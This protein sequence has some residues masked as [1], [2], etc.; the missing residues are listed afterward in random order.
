MGR[1]S[2]EESAQRWWALSLAVALATD[3]GSGNAA[4]VVPGSDR[5]PIADST[6]TIVHFDGSTAETVPEPSSVFGVMEGNLSSGG[7]LAVPD[8]VPEPGNAALLGLGLRGF[9]VAKR[10][11]L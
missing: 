2:D 5:M 10:R 8:P 1:E 6:G 4:P 9:S 11:R 3:P 7:F